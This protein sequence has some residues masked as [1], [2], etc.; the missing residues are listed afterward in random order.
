[1]EN[2]VIL[3][4]EDYNEL[5]DFKESLESGSVMIKPHKCHKYIVYNDIKILTKDET[6]K[7]LAVIANDACKDYRE[8]EKK[9]K[10]LKDESDRDK[11]L[12]K[13]IESLSPKKRKGILYRL[14]VF[15][16]RLFRISA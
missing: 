16:I 7:H 10:E 5:R 13:D 8:L 2:K 14:G 11:E 12:L 4:L 15:L 9:Y 1:M 3:K 6:V